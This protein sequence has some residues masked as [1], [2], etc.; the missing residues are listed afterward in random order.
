MQ[1]CILVAYTEREMVMTGKCLRL[2]VWAGLLVVAASVSADTGDGLMEILVGNTRKL[3]S[4]VGKCVAHFGSAGSWL[5][6]SREGP[7]RLRLI[8]RWVHLPLTCATWG[9]G[10]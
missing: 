7:A 6:V 4:G 9:R 3:F 10:R 8:H 2:S 1:D 5:S